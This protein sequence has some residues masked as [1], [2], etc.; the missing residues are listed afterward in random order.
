LVAQFSIEDDSRT[1]LRSAEGHVCTPIVPGTNNRVVMILN[2]EDAAKVDEG[3]LHYDVTDQ[4]TGI[5]HSIKRADCGL[6]CKC[7]A[8]I[9]VLA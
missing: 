9:E 3:T 6:G 5:E 8:E 4:M 7:A 2:D 1:I